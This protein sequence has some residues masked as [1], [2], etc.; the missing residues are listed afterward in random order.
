MMMMIKTEK[1]KFQAK[2]YDLLFY[3]YTH[4]QTQFMMIQR[5][6]NYR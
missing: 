5:F 4:T 1:K 6:L 2:F 3:K